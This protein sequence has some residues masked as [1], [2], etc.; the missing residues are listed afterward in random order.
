MRYAELVINLLLFQIIFLFTVGVCFG[1]DQ[2]I[3]HW[4]FVPPKSHLPPEVSDKAWVSN[5]IDN[6]ILFKLEE[7]GLE[8]AAPA[9]PYQLI[10]R[11]YYD[12]IGLPPDPDEVREYIEK[13]SFKLYKQIVDKLLD[14]PRYGEKWGRHWLDIARYG[15]SNGGDENHAYPH[16]WRYRDY[17]IDAF[18]RDIP[19]DQ[20]I[21]QQLAGDLLKSQHAEQ[22]HLITAT[23][24]LAIGTKILAEKDPVKKRADIVDEQID[25]LSRSLMGISI[26][27]ARCHDHKFDPIPTSDYYALAGILHSTSIEDRIVYRPDALNAENK[28]LSKIKHLEDDLKILES[29]FSNLIDGDAVLQIEAEKF[30]SGNVKIIEAE[31]AQ[32]A[33]YISDPG[34]QDNYAEYTLE[35]SKKGHYSIDFRYAAESSRPGKLIIDGDQENSLPVL[36][37]VTGGWSS[38]FQKW[39]NEGY[40]FFDVGEHNLR[41]ESEPLMSHLDKIKVSLVKNLE[42]VKKIN[43]DRKKAS[44]ELAKLKSESTNTYKVMAVKDGEIADMNIN[45]RGDP[46]SK[47]D[48]IKRRGLTFIKPNKGFSCDDKSSGR[49]KF[50]TWM[51][52]P[53]HP[54]TSRVIVNRIW[55]WHFG[56]GIVDTVDDFGTTGS[57]PSHPE[58]LDYLAVNFIENGWSIKQLHRQ[59]LFS[60]AYRMATDHKNPEVLKKDPNN[61]LYSRRDVRRIEAEAFR[62]SILKVSGN[63]SYDK[64]V[65]PL[66]VKSQDPSPSDLMNNRKSYESFPYRSVYLPVIRSHIYDFLSLLGFPNATA[67]MGQRPLTTVPTQALMMMNNPFLINQAK[68]LS[69]RIENGNFVNLYLLLYA[70]EPSDQES[71]WIKNFINEHTKIKGKEKA[72]EALCHTLLISNEFMHVW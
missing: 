72:W 62:D 64:P 39:I 11:V 28:R 22:T 67:S 5:E 59:I 41:I 37:E 43:G 54:L 33:T 44:L 6:F 16:A 50:A 9:S 46:H 34:S 29:K 47:G 61:D 26:S 20:F 53:D 51:T 2:K 60:S 4:S 68:S 13:P 49:L 40:A 8:P 52:Q 48:K 31:N 70:R 19:Y 65:A 14:S 71:E 45:V 32:E 23:G 25:T 27:C 3:Q 55:Y 36:S 17:V 7:N 38:K 15:D 58:L 35:I 63:L 24:F 56:K 42:S 18:N 69:E 57:N 66:K 30:T 12:L 21:H 1:E 10:R